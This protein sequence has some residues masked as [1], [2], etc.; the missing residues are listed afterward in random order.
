MARAPKM[1]PGIPASQQRAILRIPI[2]ND[3]FDCDSAAKTSGVGG[4]SKV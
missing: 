4:A 3:D 2:T 1:M